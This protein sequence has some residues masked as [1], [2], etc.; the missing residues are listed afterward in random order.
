MLLIR[1]FLHAVMEFTCLFTLAILRIIETNA[2][3]AEQVNTT[4]FLDYS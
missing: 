4:N 1:V 2:V 3:P